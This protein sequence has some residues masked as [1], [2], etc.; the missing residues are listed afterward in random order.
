MLCSNTYCYYYK[1][2]LW[3]HWNWRIEIEGNKQCSP[4]SNWEWTNIGEG[5]K[6]PR[7]I[8]PYT[9]DVSILRTKIPAFFGT[10][11]WL[12]HTF[13]VCFCFGAA[14]PCYLRQN[15]VSIKVYLPQVLKLDLYS[16]QLNQI[17]QPF[18]N[19]GGSLYAIQTIK[20]ERSSSCKIFV[21][22]C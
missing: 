20:F 22:C 3:L 17:W 12:V 15:G 8:L 11:L 16:L 7:C 4:V 18:L 6:N 14:P 19:K 13:F 1:A 10:Y 5:E 9:N 2:Y 21:F